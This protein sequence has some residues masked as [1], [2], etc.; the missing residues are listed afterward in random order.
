MQINNIPVNDSIKECQRLCPILCYIISFNL[1]HPLKI[2]SITSISQ[3]KKKIKRL[4]SRDAKQFDKT[5]APQHFLLVLGIWVC[6]A[7]QGRSFLQISH[8]P[9]LMQI[10]PFVF[11]ESLPILFYFF[12]KWESE[13]E[14]EIPAADSRSKDAK[15][16]GL[17]VG[18]SLRTQA[19]VKPH[20]PAAGLGSASLRFC[21]RE[22]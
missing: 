4:S 13:W 14:A 22:R 20:L 21:T 17:C 18:L 6:R 11:P 16:R 12:Q 3:V 15:S 7:P 8:N 2:G 10:F 1:K 5:L 19:E 9:Y